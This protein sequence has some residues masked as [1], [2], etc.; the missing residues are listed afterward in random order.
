MGLALR[1]RAGRARL[2]ISRRLGWLA[3]AA[4]A[5]PVVLAFLQILLHPWGRELWLSIFKA[6][7]LGGVAMSLALAI[8]GAAVAAIRP[9]SEGRLHV[10]EGDLVMENG[11]GVRRVPLASVR[12]GV[13][14]P[15]ARGA[16]I[17][18]SVAS[19]DSWFVDVPSLEE[20][21][22]ALR[23]LGLDAAK[24]RC[25]I[26]L[27]PRASS[28]LRRVGWVIAT[29]FT[30][31]MGLGI[32][33]EG[34]PATASSIVVWL[35][36]TTFGVGLV[37]YLTRQRE[38][39]IGADGVLLPTALG[40][41]FL[42]FDEVRGVKAAGRQVRFERS[43][44]PDVIVKAGRSASPETAATIALRVGEAM[45]A[46]TRP[47]S[48]S[49]LAMVSRAGRSLADW[50]QSMEQLARQTQSYRGV[51]L[52]SDDLAA[53]L[54]SPA[55]SEEQRI[56]AALGLLSLGNEH[57]DRLRIAASACAHEPM[58][59]ALDKLARGDVDDDAIEEA[60]ASAPKA[61]KAYM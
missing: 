39:T 45:R 28:V 11:S 23:A 2:A 27:V 26:P 55:A 51:T 3:G 5:T 32:V 6:S 42:R 20:G 48:E 50:R 22:Q 40:T 56:G 8:A 25:A 21:E 43:G 41:R 58:R 60:I 36:S 49:A 35:A 54:E 61:E 10:E 33:L 9:A 53:I 52:S 37:T 17:E 1:G 12:S 44:G 59:V 47:D 18:I 15:Q 16:R 24:R 34:R 46:R 30:A 31:F 38:I 14:V 57:K 7:L 4:L 29:V 13:V 19:G